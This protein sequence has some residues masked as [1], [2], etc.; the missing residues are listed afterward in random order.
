MKKYGIIVFLILGLVPIVLAQ[1]ANLNTPISAEEQAQFDAILEPVLRIYNF[2]KYIT[3]VIAG[4]FLLWAGVSY[5]TS[6]GDPK[7]REDA[8]NIATYVVAGL[9]LIWAAPLIVGLLL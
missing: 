2:I 4:L 3:S 5:M 7:K 6:A 8:K 9:V 1:T